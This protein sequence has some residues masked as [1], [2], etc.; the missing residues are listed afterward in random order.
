MSAFVSVG[1]FFKDHRSEMFRLTLRILYY[2]LLVF[3]ALLIAN[4]VTSTKLSHCSKG[5][6]SFGMWLNTG[7]VTGSEDKLAEFGSHFLDSEPG[8]ALQFSQVWRP[9]NCSYHRFTKE[10]LETVIDHVLSA[11]H[12]SKR[13]KSD[14]VHLLFMTDS[15]TRGQLCGIIRMIQGTEVY[16]PTEN[17]ICGYGPD[18]LAYRDTN[19][20][21]NM[22]FFDNKL[23]IHYS[24]TRAFVENDDVLDKVIHESIRKFKPHT[25]VFNTG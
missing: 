21:V 14:Q 3:L 17:I 1:G 11:K 10:S 12:G 8:E 22:T 25:F 23:V 13:P 2:I 24:Y 5:A 19:Q 18:R 16:G 15:G 9:N 7:D 20:F 6:D 4:N